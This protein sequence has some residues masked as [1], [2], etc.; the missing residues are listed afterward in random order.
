MKIIYSL[1]L[2]VLEA[3]LIVH[4]NI[5]FVKKEQCFFLEICHLEK[6]VDD[7]GCFVLKRADQL[8]T[9]CINENSVMFFCIKFH[10]SS[11]SHSRWSNYHNSIFLLFWFR[12]KSF[13]QLF[14]DFLDVHLIR[15]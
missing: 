14:L 2:H 4:D 6:Y 10:K 13:C 12:C 9:I 1:L 8:A 3:I 5:D 7:I 11:F 15:L